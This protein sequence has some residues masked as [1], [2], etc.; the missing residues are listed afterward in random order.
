MAAPTNQTRGRARVT[1]DEATIN[2]VTIDETINDWPKAG[3]DRAI[4][5]KHGGGPGRGSTDRFHVL[6][7][8]V[9]GLVSGSADVRVDLN[10]REQQWSAGFGLLQNIPR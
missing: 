1:I 5:S 3:R 6:L 10:D 7:A 8:L 2:E 4:G 9:R